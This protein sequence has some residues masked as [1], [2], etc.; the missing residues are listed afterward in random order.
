MGWRMKMFG[1][2]HP[3]R[4]RY[5]AMAVLYAFLAL[6][7]YGLATDFLP[8]PS[9]AIVMV[10]VAGVVALLLTAWMGWFTLSGRNAAFNGSKWRLVWLLPLMAVFAWVFA[11]IALARGIPGAVT[12]AF[13]TKIVLAP[14]V[15]WTDD[16]Y[17]RRECKYQLRGGVLDGFLRDHLCVKS[18]YFNAHPNHRVEVRLVGRRSAMGVAPSGFVHLRDLGGRPRD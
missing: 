16:R 10:R 4:K 9:F 3:T 13:G 11:W 12:R 15:M 7:F 2:E 17:H 6:V 18:A 5:L 8:E 1:A 14:A